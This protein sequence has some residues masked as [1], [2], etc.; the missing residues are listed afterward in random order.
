MKVT[1]TGAERL[2][3]QIPE[4]IFINSL[5]DVGEFVYKCEYSMGFN[6]EMG[7]FVEEMK[8]SKNDYIKEPDGKIW[9]RISSE[10][11]DFKEKYWKD[12]LILFKETWNSD[13]CNLLRAKVSK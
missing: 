2:E 13:E 3:N 5:V 7:M 4:G 12:A 9:N 6:G 11:D 1:I 10:N 8:A